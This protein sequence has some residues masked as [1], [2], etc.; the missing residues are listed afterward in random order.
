MRTCVTLCVHVATS[1]G[2]SIHMSDCTVGN[3]QHDSRPLGVTWCCQHLVDTCPAYTCVADGS[4]TL[5]RERA[6]HNVVAGPLF[7]K[8]ATAGVL[9]VTNVAGRMAFSSSMLLI[10]NG[11]LSVLCVQDHTNASLAQCDLDF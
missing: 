10:C 2:V 1:V 7:S 4:W 3:C 8:L 5:A 11:N 6:K 9:Q